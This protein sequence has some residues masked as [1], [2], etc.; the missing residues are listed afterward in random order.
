MHGA[1]FVAQAR[2]QVGKAPHV[3]EAAASP[4]ASA[5]GVLTLNRPQAGNVVIFDTHD[6]AIIDFR[7]IANQWIALVPIA[8]MLRIVFRDGAVIE[9]LNFFS[10]G[11]AD[12]SSNEGQ[13]H[14]HDAGRLRVERCSGADHRHR[15]FVAG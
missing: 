11:L 8:G 7:L 1:M 6:Y 13:S 3:T 10:S 12:D 14:G 15:V 9:L 4:R 5:E 2:H